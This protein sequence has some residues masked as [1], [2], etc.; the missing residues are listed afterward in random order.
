MTGFGYDRKI[1]P[2]DITR[3]YGAILEPTIRAGEKSLGFETAGRL[4]L[5]FLHPRQ[6]YTDAPV[7]FRVI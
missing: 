4:P 7:M 6:G 2:P 5:A 3:R 1:P